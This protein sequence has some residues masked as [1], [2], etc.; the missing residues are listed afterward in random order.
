[1]KN[2]GM[3]FHLRNV[4]QNAPIFCN[5][6]P[7]R[8]VYSDSVDLS[9]LHFH[10]YVEISIVLAG[11][12]RHRI[13]GQT[14]SCRSGDIYVINIGVPH[15]YFAKSET[16]YPVVC[17]LPFHAADWFEG[18]LA[19]ANDPRFCYGIFEHNT[20]F[21]HTHFTP[22]LLTKLMAFYGAVARETKQAQDDWKA[23]AGANLTLLLIMLERH[24]RDTA[25]HAAP[26]RLKDW[27]IVS[28]AI[29]AAK[30]HIANGSTDATL[31][32]LA[33]RF[34]ISKSY[35]SRLFLRVTGERYCDYIRRARIL[36]ACR[37][38]T[39]TQWS[40]A[41]IAR[42]CGIRDLQTFYRLF[43]DQMQTTPNQF[44]KQH[45]MHAQSEP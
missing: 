26:V 29:Q 41:Q 5:T 11:S 37:L 6:V 45:A 17:N 38:L 4:L 35:L 25:F 3:P 40:N 1:M 28:N 15:G 32:T 14:F 27:I 24:V 13:L 33:S 20:L 36:Q 19:D 2:S 44:R 16:E 21:S 30:E 42:E 12:G 43:K 23:A 10:D 39:E 22:D 31:E 34:F 9:K 8:D 7:C 18:S